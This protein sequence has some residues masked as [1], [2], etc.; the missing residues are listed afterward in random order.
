MTTYQRK[1]AD[2]KPIEKISE[3]HRRLDDWEPF[4]KIEF[5][6]V[7][8]YKESELSGDEWRVGVH[9]KFWFK[10][11]LIQEEFFHDMQQA[12][13]MI[14]SMWL[15]ISCPIPNKVI[16][17][18]KNLCDQPGCNNPAEHKLVLKKRAGR[19]GWVEDDGSYPCVYYRKFCSK[20]LT[21][22]N[23]GLEDADRNYVEAK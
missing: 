6:V 18:E 10:E 11:N 3:F 12:L 20:H 13:M 19:E 7:P 8:R 9:V 21:R 5:K 1:T 14:P 16:E 17:I 23:C 15:Q 22:G 4:D 2:L